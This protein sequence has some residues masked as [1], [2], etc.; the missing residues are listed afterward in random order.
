MKPVDRLSRG[1]FEAHPVWEFVGED[2]PDET[3]VRPVPALPV[4][5]LDR[6]LVGCEVELADGKRVFAMLG[7]VH[8]S[9]ARANKHLLTLS[10]LIRGDWFHLA[11][12]HDVSRETHGP[13]ALARRLELSVNQVFPIR[14]DLRPYARGEL[15][16]LVGAIDREPDEPL[17]RSKLIE[18][19]LG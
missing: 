12:Y 11:R 17:P 9:D 8:V 6:R 7:N 19:I 1:D 5:S 4:D 2:E 3:A 14:Y 16:A 10:V 15:A 13:A 18:L